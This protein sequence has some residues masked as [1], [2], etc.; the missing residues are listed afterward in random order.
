MTEGKKTAFLSLDP[1][2]NR[3]NCLFFSK[4]CLARTRESC[5]KKGTEWWLI[6]LLLHIC[7]IGDLP[8]FNFFKLASLLLYEI[9]TCT[10]FLRSHRVFFFWE[11]LEPGL[12]SVLS[13]LWLMFFLPCRSIPLLNTTG[14]LHKKRKLKE[15]KRNW[16]NDET[17]CIYRWVCKHA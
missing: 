7:E 10:W 3:C 8:D 5:S 13:C 11:V 15:R 9:S 16:P 17:I 4:W 14:N 12:Y 1:Y 2:L 6:I